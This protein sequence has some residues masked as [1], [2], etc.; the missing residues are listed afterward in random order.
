[1]SRQTERPGAPRSHDR[2]GG[3]PVVSPR[4][5]AEQIPLFEVPIS[6]KPAAPLP[7]PRSC[8]R[9]DR[10]LPPR[11]RHRHCGTC[12]AEILRD[13]LQAGPSGAPR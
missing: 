8:P 3:R 9:C 4:T 11:Y 1:M 13:W 10:A 7:P 5:P 6:R 12:H 2:H